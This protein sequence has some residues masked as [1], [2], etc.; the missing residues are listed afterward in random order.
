MPADSLFSSSDDGQDLRTELEQRLAV[1][2]EQ[3][4]KALAERDH[5]EAKLA[6]L[7]EILEFTGDRLEEAQSAAGAGEKAQGQVQAL[8]GKLEGLEAELREA[9]ENAERAYHLLHEYEDL[10][11]DAEERAYQAE[12]NLWLVEQRLK[13]AQAATSESSSSDAPLH[14]I[15]HNLVERQMLKITLDLVVKQGAR[16]QRKVALLSIGLLGARDLAPMQPL[17]AKRLAKI[18]RD[19]DMLGRL[20]EETFGILV[21]EQTELE[22]IRFIARCIARR[23]E[24]V[25][26]GPIVVRGTPH[27]LRVVIGVSIYPSDA[28]TACLVLDHAETVL[29]EAQ[30]VAQPGL[31]FYRLQP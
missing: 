9:R 15:V 22:D 13:E 24:S 29:A 23:A 28:P 10:T 7:E 6:E 2:E 30:M 25:F 26:E 5:S 17:I 20:S 14:N 31:H 1:A 4:L 19:S 27:H 12:H 16:H 3:A 18:V 11:V 21:S 8:H